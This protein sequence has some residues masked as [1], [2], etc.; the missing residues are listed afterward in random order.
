MQADSSSQR[1]KGLQMASESTFIRFVRGLHNATAHG[2]AVWHRSGEGGQRVSFETAHGGVSIHPEDW[3]NALPFVLEIADPSGT[4][5][6]SV[7]TTYEANEEGEPRLT[8]QS[9]EIVRLYRAA[10][11][12]AVVN[13]IDGILADLDREE[14]F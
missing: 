12:S 2:R 10:R 1:L 8:S 3:D 4:V 11:D 14:P 13:V 9:E 5:V 7:V 6:E